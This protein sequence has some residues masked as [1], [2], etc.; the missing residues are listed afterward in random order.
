MIITV[1]LNP[2]IDKTARVEAIHP[3]A[4][5]RLNEIEKDVGGKGI[6]VSKAIA[7]LGGNSTACGFLGGAT[8][9]LIEDMIREREPGI[10]P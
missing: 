6:N 4:L 5:N 3:R 1:T 9:R 8:G 10:T 2:A 7:A